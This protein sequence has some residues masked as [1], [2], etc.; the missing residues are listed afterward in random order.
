MTALLLPLERLQ[1]PPLHRL[2]RSSY[3]SSFGSFRRS[4]QSVAQNPPKSSRRIAW[5]TPGYVTRSSVSAIP[6][7]AARTLAALIAGT[8]ARP[9]CVRLSGLLSHT[10]RGYVSFPAQTGQCRVSD[11]SKTVLQDRSRHKRADSNWILNEPI[12]SIRVLP[13]GLLV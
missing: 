11:P 7:Y 1:V 2:P 10:A 13:V 4:A 9:V 12:D 5:C 6:S 8:L 3:V